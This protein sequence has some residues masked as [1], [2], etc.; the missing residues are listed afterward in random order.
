MTVQNPIIDIDL[1]QQEIKSIKSPELKKKY[2][3][4]KIELVNQSLFEDTKIS[5]TNKLEYLESRIAYL[6]KIFIKKVLAS[7]LIFNENK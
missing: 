3:Q 6:E 4:E 7:Y 1:V 5:F 2:V